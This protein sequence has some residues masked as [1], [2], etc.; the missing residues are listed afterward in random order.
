MTELAV[1]LQTVTQQVS[2]TL[3]LLAPR[4]A[5]NLFKQFLS[6]IKSARKW[7]ACS[8]FSTLGQWPTCL[9]Q[10]A[11]RYL[12][13]GG[14]TTW[15]DCFFARNRQ[16]VLSSV[17][18]KVAN[19]HVTIL[20]A[21]WYLPPDLYWRDNEQSNC[22]NL[23]VRL[24]YR[25]KIIVSYLLHVMALSFSDSAKMFSAR[26][27]NRVLFDQS[28]QDQAFWNVQHSSQGCW[29]RAE[30]PSVLQCQT[31]L[32]WI[33]FWESY[34]G[35]YRIRSPCEQCWS[36]SW[37]DRL[38]CPWVALSGS[39]DASWLDSRSCY[40]L[41]PTH[42]DSVAVVSCMCPCWA[43]TL[44]QQRDSPKQQWQPTMASAFLGGCCR[45]Q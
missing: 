9:Q 8:G 5:T 22:S 38:E 18:L 27:S 1:G 23:F 4:P 24:P 7:L 21:R 11:K 16:E 33:P 19:G 12:G 25:S 45:T 13:N 17:F 28:H 31:L 29:P 43:E 35:C 44:L 26:Q 2:N 30:W 36:K 41:G 34:R 39:S 40:Q 3:H 10:L 20:P 32:L 15:R 14:A 42:Q 37:Q 6:L